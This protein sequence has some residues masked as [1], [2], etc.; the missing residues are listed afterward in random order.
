MGI[1]TAMHIGTEPVLGLT[2]AD[3]LKMFEQDEQTKAVAIFGEIGGTLEEE[4]A[5]TV[6]SGQFTKPLVV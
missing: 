3:V 1:S 4:A 2:M 6:A 5:E